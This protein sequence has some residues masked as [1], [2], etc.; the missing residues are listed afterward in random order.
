VEIDAHGVLYQKKGARRNSGPPRERATSLP[1]RGAAARAL[2]TLLAATLVVPAVLAFA[3]HVGLA[4][5]VLTA[6]RLAVVELD[7]LADF[8]VILPLAALRLPTRLR[9]LPL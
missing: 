9:I 6:L 2:A 1:V 3:R 4:R 8:L 5:L 7:R